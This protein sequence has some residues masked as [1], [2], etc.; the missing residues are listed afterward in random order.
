MMCWQQRS[1]IICSSLD[2][3]EVKARSVIL[4]R[5]KVIG[6]SSDSTLNVEYYRQRSVKL[7]SSGQV[8]HLNVSANYKTALRSSDVTNS[9][10]IIGLWFVSQEA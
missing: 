9:Q 7:H 1:S 3:G 2:I 5:S 4:R 8:F 6:V 10:V